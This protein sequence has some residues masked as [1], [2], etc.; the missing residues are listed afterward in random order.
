MA[1]TNPGDIADVIR[2]TW[3]AR[4]LSD[5][6]ERLYAEYLKDIDP[7]VLRGALVALVADWDHPAPPGIIRAAA[8]EQAKRTRRKKAWLQVG[9]AAGI[10]VVVLGGIL[11]LR[12]FLSGGRTSTSPAA[13]GATTAPG[14]RVQD[15]TASLTTCTGAAVTRPITF[16][17]TCADGNYRLVAVHWQ[18]WGTAQAVATGHAS[19]NNCAP[20]CAAGQTLD[21]RVRVTASDPI[22]GP[23]GPAYARLSINY[24]HAPPRG[25]R[26]PDVWRIGSRGP[27][28][29]SGPTPGSTQHTASAAAHRPALAR[30]CSSFYDAKLGGTA[31]IEFGA[32]ASGGGPYLKTPPDPSGINCTSARRIIRDLQAGK[33]TPFHGR[34]AYNTYTVVDGWKCATTTEATSC[35]KGTLSFIAGTGL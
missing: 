4:E 33:G 18:N 12:A 32:R 28:S 8:R 3:P 20:D 30:P 26:N 7:D 16:T 34:Y 11:G 14:S 21:Y 35:S 27:R 13:T 17:M 6:Q 24:L 10:I 1:V 23:S 31:K 19:M 29:R 5:A 15:Q 9:L 22:A 2:S 25:I